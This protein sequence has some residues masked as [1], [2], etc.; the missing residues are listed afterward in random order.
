MSCNASRG[1]ITRCLSAVLNSRAV[2]NTV[3][4]ESIEPPS[5]VMPSH[6]AAA[7]YAYYPQSS[8]VLVS[9]ETFHG[10]PYYDYSHHH[11]H[12]HHPA[13]C[14]V[15]R[16]KTGDNQRSGQI[17]IHRPIPVQCR[18]PFIVAGIGTEMEE[19]LERIVPNGSNMIHSYGESNMSNVDT[20]T[21]HNGAAFYYS[22]STNGA[23]SS[24]GS[25]GGNSTPHHV[26]SA[27][28]SVISG[29]YG[30]SSASSPY[31]QQPHSITSSVSSSSMTP[32]SAK[33]GQSSTNT[34]TT[35]QR[36]NQTSTPVNYGG[37]YC[38]NITGSPVTSPM[39]IHQL[40]RCHSNS[41]AAATAAVI[42][43]NPNTPYGTNGPMTPGAPV[44]S[45]NGPMTPGSMAQPMTPNGGNPC[46]PIQLKREESISSCGSPYPSNSSDYAM[47][48]NGSNTK[49]MGQQQQQQQQQGG[50]P[51]SNGSLKR[52]P[53]VEPASPY[54]TR[55][56]SSSMGP[57]P[58]N[59]VNRNTSSSPASASGPGT[60]YMANQSYSAPIGA[61]NG[62]GGNGYLTPY[63]QPQYP[64]SVSA[65]YG[66]DSSIYDSEADIDDSDIFEDAD[67]E[68]EQFKRL[69]NNDPTI[70][71]TN[72]VALLQ[73]Q[74]R[75]LEANTDCHDRYVRRQK[76]QEARNDL[77]ALLQINHFDDGSFVSNPSLSSYVDSSAYD[78]GSGDE[79]HHCQQQRQQQQRQTTKMINPL[80]GQFSPIF[81]HHQQRQQANHHLT[82]SHEYASIQQQQQ[83]QQQQANGHGCSSFNHYNHY[84][85]AHHQSHSQSQFSP[86]NSS[87]NGV[88]QSVPNYHMQN[89]NGNS[90]YGVSDQSPNIHHRTSLQSYPNTFKSINRS[91]G[92]TN[93]D[94][95]LR[96]PPTNTSHPYGV[97]ASNHHSKNVQF[98][99]DQLDPVSS[100]LLTKS[101]TTGNVI[102]SVSFDPKTGMMKI[103]KKRGRPRKN[104][105]PP[106]PLP[107][108][109]SL[110]SL[111]NVSD[112]SRTFSGGQ[113]SPGAFSSGSSSLMSS[114]SSSSSI[115]GF[116]SSRIVN[117]DLNDDHFKSN[118]KNDSYGFHFMDQSHSNS[119][120]HAQ[121]NP[122]IMPS[123]I[124]K[125]EEM[126]SD[127]SEDESP[128]SIS[129]NDDEETSSS[130]NDDE[131]DDEDDED[132]VNDLDDSKSSS[133]SSS[134]TTNGNANKRRESRGSN[135]NT[136]PSSNNSPNGSKTSHASISINKGPIFTRMGPNSRPSMFIRR[137]P[138]ASMGKPTFS[139]RF[140]SAKK[141][142]YHQTV[143]DEDEYDDEDEEEE[144]EED[145]NADDK[146]MRGKGTSLNRMK[147]NPSSDSPKIR[148][149]VTK[150]ETAFVCSQIISE[151][152][153]AAATT[154]ITT[155]TNNN[156]NNNNKHESIDCVVRDLVTHLCDM[157]S[158]TVPNENVSIDK[159]HDN[160]LSLE[161]SLIK[162]EN[163]R[164]YPI[165]H[166]MIYPD[167]NVYPNRPM[168]P[169]LN[170]VPDMAPHGQYA[171]CSPFSRPYPQQLP[172]Q[173]LQQ[174]QQ[175]QQQQQSY[176]R[177]YLFQHQSQPSLYGHQPT[178]VSAQ[179][180][181]SMGYHTMSSLREFNRTSNH[182]IMDRNKT[183]LSPHVINPNRPVPGVA[184][185]GPVQP[186]F[187][188]IPA[189]ISSNSSPNLSQLLSSNNP[190][191]VFL[192]AKQPTLIRDKLEEKLRNVSSFGS[193]E[194]LKDLLSEMADPK[195][196]NTDISNTL[197]AKLCSSS[198][199]DVDLTLDDIFNDSFTT[200]PSNLE[201]ELRQLQELD[202]ISNTTSTS[203]VSPDSTS[204]T[205]EK[206]MLN[207]SLLDDHN[208]NV[209]NA[210]IMDLL[211]DMTDYVVDCENLNKNQIDDD[212]LL[213][214]RRMINQ[215]AKDIEI[216]NKLDMLNH[217]DEHIDVVLVN[218][219]VELAC[220]DNI[221]DLTKLDTIADAEITQLFKGGSKGEKL[222]SKRRRS[223][224][225]LVDM[226]E[227]STNDQNVNNCRSRSNSIQ[228]KSKVSITESCS[229]PVT[230]VTSPES[231]TWSPM[232]RS[233]TQTPPI[234]TP[235][236]QSGV[237]NRKRQFE[238]SNKVDC[239]QKSTN[240][241][242]FKMDENNYR[243]IVP[244]EDD[245][246]ESMSQND[247]KMATISNHVI[248]SNNGSLVIDIRH[249]SQ[250]SPIP[251]KR[252]KLD[253]LPISSSSVFT[254]NENKD[255]EDGCI[256][257]SVQHPDISSSVDI[258]NQHKS[259]CCCNRNKVVPDDM[260]KCHLTCRNGVSSHSFIVKSTLNSTKNDNNNA[261]LIAQ[262]SPVTIHHHS[263]SNGAIKT[264]SI[265]FDAQNTTTIIHINSGSKSTTTT[266]DSI[267]K[268]LSTKMS[269]PIEAITNGT[270]SPNID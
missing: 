82:S 171:R 249:D 137:S 161:K 236:E 10:I 197:K 20:P 261:K 241:S 270:S 159:K 22:P 59:I 150:T 157:V 78:I 45:T 206:S 83:Q 108:P 73:D 7:A 130:S 242:K 109:I 195:H 62:V 165:N 210:E 46:T 177:P 122:A 202:V 98:I 196:P 233:T 141:I 69:S 199:V 114:S 139:K 205:Q 226:N 103:K 60:P 166:S 136:R 3:I 175:Q 64:P 117:D 33:S 16:R 232:V 13:A 217:K 57:S 67:E 47:F 237:N 258:D 91:L 76:M 9:M 228:L 102:E 38:D 223:W 32:P 225:V 24:S 104:P 253:Y 94:I 15:R 145:D 5:R 44:I 235:T 72:H 209:N 216:T 186:Q 140:I 17:A 111:T 215:V 238:E 247:L 190:T 19:L 79:S 120:N 131:Q 182:L 187:R 252:T 123:N 74:L 164:S 124:I 263:D 134:P 11:H 41:S 267:E 207:H 184:F 39:S 154:T 135:N 245:D 23:G 185:L 213:V 2:L 99:N 142:N 4:N 81:Q 220:H 128:F 151:P 42:N 55:L 115:N 169:T 211:H 12:H 63:H 180:V 266:S 93:H 156:N 37:I 143:S 34:T 155:T 189:P 268:G 52:S 66:M 71:A 231:S 160:Y 88:I 21:S 113:K 259:T 222:R 26:M 121:P 194:M 192:E 264:V 43:S 173:H 49:R 101:A 198:Q 243:P 179:P 87:T 183:Q 68:N 221:D 256:E 227:S 56:G 28:N 188:P 61:G 106:P 162:T 84:Q 54:N 201:E 50:S 219:I 174:Q 85:Q 176:I 167:G 193:N 163:D 158:T 14:F 212:I 48:T 148:L 92:A 107:P 53:S 138:S 269:E 144:E 77:Q 132:A 229:S 133:S 204:V 97:M 152:T 181:Q 35:I 31:G 119:Y 65:S 178:V 255:I 25:N 29:H 170:I 240:K 246:D 191:K 168:Q 126:T 265:N 203:S 149:K 18:L 1:N 250:Q 224:E 254:K 51:A 96:S 86:S 147:P 257:S 118:G 146:E 127:S 239:Y 260:N 218:D 95:S 208:S 6:T 200:D 234:F 262:Q 36:P 30:S 244:Y 251:T 214:V 125:K 110:Q 100:A 58:V 153:S 40:P 172:Q 116:G 70:Y 8:L 80:N 129:S 112:R 105:L 27:P 230:S 75:S 248:K 90:I 89:G